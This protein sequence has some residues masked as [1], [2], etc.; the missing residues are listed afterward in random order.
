MGLHITR[1]ARKRPMDKA[2][3]GGGGELGR[4]MTLPFLALK[5]CDVGAPFPQTTVTFAKLHP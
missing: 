2:G 5:A 1:R 3:N 4:G